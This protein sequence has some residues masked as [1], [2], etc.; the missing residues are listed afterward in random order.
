MGLGHEESLGIV[1]W[2][3]D[4]RNISKYTTSRLDSLLVFGILGNILALRS[5]L[6]A[7]NTTT[8]SAPT[9]GPT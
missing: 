8:P 3:A 6:S 1:L 4:G 2:L 7:M 5:G 9:G